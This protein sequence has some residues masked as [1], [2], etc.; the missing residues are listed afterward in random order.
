MVKLIGKGAEADLLLDNDVLRK[1]RSF[2]SY[3]LRELDDSIRKSRTRSESKILQKVGDIGP[4]FLGG[5]D[6]QEIRMNFIQGDLVKNILDS[7]VSLAKE[8]GL[9]VGLLH[10]LNVVHGDLTTSNMILSP[11]G[12]KIID[13][14]LSFISDKVEDK[15]VDLHL[16][17]E[18]VESKHFSREDEIWSAFLEGY[19][20]SNRDFVL[21]RLNVVESRGRNKLKY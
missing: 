3:R 8:I 19:S 9:K 17:R 4:G 1:V 15:A 21:K 5:D 18:A 16:F 14:G 12:L 20:P 7:N 11:Q 6:I 13:F 2:K 10:D